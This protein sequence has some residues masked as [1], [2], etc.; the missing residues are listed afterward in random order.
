ML[1]QSGH[2]NR[3]PAVNVHHATRY[4]ESLELPLNTFV[5]INFSE[6]LAADKASQLFRKLLNQRF[7]PWLR[8][9]APIKSAPLPTYVWA[10][11]NANATTAAHW[12]VHVPDNVKRAFSRKLA[13]WVESVTGLRPNSNAL[14]VKRIYNVIGAKRYILKGINPVWAKHLGVNASDQGIICGRRSG[15]SRNLGP[16]ARSRGGYRPRRIWSA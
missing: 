8:R 7:A 12:L 3:V 6:L 2:I 5:T 9:S 4:A 16:T 1:A 15:F 11:E 14:Q 10:L 13:D